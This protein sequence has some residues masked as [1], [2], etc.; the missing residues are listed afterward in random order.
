[1]C[2]YYVYTYPDLAI[3]LLIQWYTGHSSVTMFMYVANW[4][5]YKYTRQESTLL[6]VTQWGTKHGV[7]YVYPML[8]KNFHS[9][10]ADIDECEIN[11]CT[12]LSGSI[13]NNTVGS[14]ECVCPPGYIRCSS[15]C[16]WVY[17]PPIY[18]ILQQTKPA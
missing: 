16:G 14:Y 2:S 7:I 18:Y 1:M 13:C 12:Y 6:N 15:Q 3:I 10:D 8:F 5:T 11:D 4:V 17:I 9:N